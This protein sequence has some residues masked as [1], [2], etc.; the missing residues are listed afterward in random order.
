MENHAHIFFAGEP[1]LGVHSSPSLGWRMW[2]SWIPNENPPSLSRCA[3][4]SPVR[5]AERR[6]P[7][8]RNP[9]LVMGKVSVGCPNWRWYGWGIP[10]LPSGGP[11]GR[12]NPISK[13]KDPSIDRS[14]DRSLGFEKG[15]GS[16]DPSIDPLGSKRGKDP[17]IHRSIP[18]VR[19]GGRI[20]RSIDRSLGFEKGEGSI[21][22]SIDPLGS[23]RGKDPSI[24][25]SIPWGEGSIDPSIDRSLGKGTGGKCQPWVRNPGAGVGA[26][27]KDT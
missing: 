27:R 4:C 19:K 12:S 14:I 9:R 21:D 18:W 8:W 11:I 17:S 5:L 6:V 24:H 15:E 1:S 16:I 13:G 3:L 26:G 22:P 2:P 25:R 10:R 7:L 20:H 23:K